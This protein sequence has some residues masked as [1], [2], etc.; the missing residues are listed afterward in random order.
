MLAG[1]ARSSGVTLG[2]NYS[3]DTDPTRFTRGTPEPPA[4]PAPAAPPAPWLPG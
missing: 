1:V 4:A 2:A 3:T